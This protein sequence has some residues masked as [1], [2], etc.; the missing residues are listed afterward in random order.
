MTWQ[1][2]LDDMARRRE[3]AKEMGGP[4]RVAKHKSQGKLTVRERID[5]LVD[6]GSFTEIGSLSGYAEY[7]E[8]N[9][10]QKLTPSS[11]V[12]G[13]AKIDGRT[14]VVGAN[15][16]T[17]RAPGDDPGAGRKSAM[18]ERLAPELRVPL[19]RM[20]DGFGGSVRTQESI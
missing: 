5:G 13:R 16:F 14:V 19:I 8:N 20:I 1:A 12:L 3:M 10:L 7:D 11:F 4:E 15:D 6:T 18:A 2:E 9:Q 17:V